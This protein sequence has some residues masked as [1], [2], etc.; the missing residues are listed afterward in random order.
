MWWR[1]LRLRPIATDDLRAVLAHHPETGAFVDNVEQLLPLLPAEM[2]A[3]FTFV[4]QSRSPERVVDPLHPRV[5]LFSRDARLL[6]AFTGDPQG[7]SRDVLDV[8][9]FSDE[10]RAFE[11]ERF[12]L[13]AAARRS[14]ELAKA[15]RRQWPAQSANV[16]SLPT[17]LIRGPSSIP[18]FSVA[19]FLRQ[20]ARPLL[21]PE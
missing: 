7:P 12:V 9:H 1:Q 20:R 11:L 15:R 17:A 5:A 8:I 18:S 3:N 21:T 14:A 2:R 16:P 19:R 10:A 6:L 4:Y 13:P